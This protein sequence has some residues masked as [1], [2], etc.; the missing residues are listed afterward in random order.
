MDDIVCATCGAPW[1]AG[2][3]KCECGGTV[4]ARR[5]FAGAHF[6]GEAIYVVLQ[7]ILAAVAY[8][9]DE[10][11]AVGLSVFGS[12]TSTVIGLVM[13]TKVITIR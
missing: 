8:W 2:Q 6:K 11:R 3:V 9:T 13:I 10:W 7:V 4:T 1:P 5:K 12:V